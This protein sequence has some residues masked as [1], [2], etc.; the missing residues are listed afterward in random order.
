MFKALSAVQ[1]VLRCP[2]CFDSIKIEDRIAK[3]D[4][5]HSFDIA[6]QGYVNFL[7]KQ[8]FIKNADTAAMVDARQKMHARPFFQDLAQQIADICVDLCRGVP[9]PIIVEP[10]GGTGLYAHAASR[11]LVNALAVSFD[12]SVQAAKVCARQSERVAAVVAD[13]WQQWPIADDSADVVLSVFSPRNFAE[14]ERILKADAAFIVVTPEENHLGELRKQFN[15][16]GI[17]R[18]KSESISSALGNFTK[19][20][21]MSHQS[22][23]LLD[24]SAMYD[25]LL[26][27]PNGHHIDAK[28][29]QVFTHAEPI[30]VTHC[31]NISVW[32]VA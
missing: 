6:R 31:V 29:V 32:K 7:T 28:D 8:T 17:Q 30:E 13:V 10:G 15:A 22:T 21:H 26:S 3:C 25:T 14:T 27:G 16:L 23:E 12:I 9:Q 1:D 18:D 2:H 20:E 4:A 5:G 19:I 11:A 24:G